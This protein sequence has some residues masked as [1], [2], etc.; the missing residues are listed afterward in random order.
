MLKCV[1]KHSDINECLNEK[2][3]DCAKDVKL[4]CVDTPGSY[5]CKCAKGYIK[6]L[7]GSCID[8]NEC[9][10]KDACP[11]GN[12]CVNLP[13]DFNCTCQNGYQ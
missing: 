10:D 4:E 12:I 11:A 1:L 5:F 7:N 13:G 8:E 3:N 6:A 9:L 2:L